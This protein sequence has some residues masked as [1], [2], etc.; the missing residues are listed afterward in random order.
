LMAGLR[1]NSEFA[2]SKPPRPF[3]ARFAGTDEAIKKGECSGSNNAAAHL[4]HTECARVALILT[5]CWGRR[6]ASL[7]YEVSKWANSRQ[8]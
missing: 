6:K 3:L 7:R 2:D 4:S 8:N 5:F 1:I